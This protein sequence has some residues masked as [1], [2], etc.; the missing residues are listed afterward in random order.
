M[1]AT[2]IAETAPGELTVSGLWIDRS[3]P[4]RPWIHPRTTGLLPMR[5][6][7]STSH[8][9]GRTWGPRRRVDTAPHPAASPTDPLLRLPGGVSAQPYE[10]WKEYEDASPARPAAHLRL[11]FDRGVTWPEH[12]TV[13]AH[14]ASELYYWDQRLAVHP[15]SGRLIAMFWTHDPRA[16]SDVDVHVAWGDPRGRT[17]SAPRGTGL[18]GQHCYP[19]ALGGDRLVAIYVHRRDPPGI[20]AVPSADF[21]RTWDRSQEVVI[22]DSAAGTEPGAAGPRA[23]DDYWSDMLAWRFGNPR[24]VLL[25]SGEVFA[26]HYAGSGQGTGIRWVRLAV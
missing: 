17:W 23:I 10:H 24:G 12:V 7:H 21:G 15:E 13:A 5:I 8:D 22:Y 2:W 3:D 9:G 25:P 4:A 14:P 1:K 11:S 6:F 18:P 20:R 19:I 26:V 16:G